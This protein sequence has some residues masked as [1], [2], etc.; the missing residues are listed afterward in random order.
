M[1]LKTHKKSFFLASLPN[2]SACSDVLHIVLKSWSIFLRKPLLRS[3][4]P[5]SFA[6]LIA[7]LQ[8]WA[9]RSVGGEST[10]YLAACLYYQIFLLSFFILS[11]VF[12][13]PVYKNNFLDYYVA[14]LRDL[15]EC[16]SLIHVVILKEVNFLPA[17]Q[18]RN[19]NMH[20]W[21]SSCCVSLRQDFPANPVVLSL[22]VSFP[23]VS[24][25]DRHL[26]KAALTW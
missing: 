16:I 1:N 22:S 12:F 13:P 4:E 17:S 14:Y 11:V 21:F 8:S 10:L 20:A 25:A 26:Q 5:W 23:S 7:L 9:P 6:Q 15:P 3:P 2:S 18:M 19:G 24:M